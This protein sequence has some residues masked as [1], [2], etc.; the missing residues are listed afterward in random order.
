MIFGIQNLFTIF[1][2][3]T[4]LKISEKW[5]NNSKFI[6]AGIA[7][8][9]GLSILATNQ[10]NIFLI[11]I[12][13]ICTSFFSLHYASRLP[14]L[15]NSL[16]LSEF[17]AVALDSLMESGVILFGSYFVYLPFSYFPPVLFFVYLI[18]I[19]TASLLYINK[20]IKK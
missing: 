1:F 14:I 18:T 13:A 17:N 4:L 9:F 10:A 6:V 3:V 12:Y 15:K 20:S 7:L 16:K 11:L 8:L 19:V 2:S 5:I